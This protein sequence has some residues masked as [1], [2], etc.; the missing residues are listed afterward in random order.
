[1]WSTTKPNEINTTDSIKLICI[2]CK[3][4]I[5]KRQER[6]GKAICEK[7]EQTHFPERLTA[8]SE[9]PYYLGNPQ[10]KRQKKEQEIFLKMMT[11]AFNRFF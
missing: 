6:N 2:M 10:T 4:A 7:C 9:D 11:R 3:K 5:E 1:M 8:R